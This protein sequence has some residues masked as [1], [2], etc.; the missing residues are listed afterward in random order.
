MLRRRWF[1]SQIIERSQAGVLAAIEVHR[2]ELELLVICKRDRLHRR[3]DR[4]RRRK[5]CW[6]RVAELAPNIGDARCGWRARAHQRWD[7]LHLGP[8]VEA[9]LTSGGR[10]LE[11][12]WLVAVDRCCT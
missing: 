10:W 9:R 8:R 4:S 3:A 12:A 11:E 6:D 7:L 5:W 2:L 1:R